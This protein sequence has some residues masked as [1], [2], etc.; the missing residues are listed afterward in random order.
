MSDDVRTAA[1]NRRIVSRFGLHL[2]LLDC[3]PSGQLPALHN[4]PVWET[5]AVEMKT[6]ISF[7]SRLQLANK[8]RDLAL[9]E[10]TDV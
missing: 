10:Q 8:I 4:D 9:S 1:E 6:R 5:G 7:A 2:A 3:L